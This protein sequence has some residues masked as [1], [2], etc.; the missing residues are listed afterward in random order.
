MEKYYVFGPFTGQQSDALILGKREYGFALWNDG[1]MA[2]QA[3]AALAKIR[4]VRP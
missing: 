2:G 1:A 3:A 4:A